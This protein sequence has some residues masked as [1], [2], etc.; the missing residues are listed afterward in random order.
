MRLIAQ[1]LTECGLLAISGGI[2]GLSLGR[3]AGFV[4]LA[5]FSEKIAVA[6][7]A[8]KT[9]FIVGGVVVLFAVAA[10]FFSLFFWLGSPMLWNKSV[11]FAK[12]PKSTSPNG[13][14]ATIELRRREKLLSEDI[15]FVTGCCSVVSL[16]A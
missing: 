9:I 10:G 11:A 6:G 1:W 12:L 2:L 14:N 15:S 7:L 3:L 4:G 5:G 8:A 16:S 13:K